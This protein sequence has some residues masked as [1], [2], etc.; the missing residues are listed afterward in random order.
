MS[1]VLA[2]EPKVQVVLDSLWERFDEF[3]KANQSINLTDWTSYLT[4]D[5]VG[6]LCISEPLGFIRDRRDKMGFISGVHEAF[7]WC[8]NL[9][10]LPWK[11][12][13]VMNPVMDFLA[14]RLDLRI[15]N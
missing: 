9:G 5:V 10:Y 4:Y 1:A 14:P 7:Y 8:A 11:A 6:T 13:W 15:A 3:A 12:A 2:T